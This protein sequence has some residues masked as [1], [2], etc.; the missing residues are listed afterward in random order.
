MLVYVVGVISGFVSGFF[1]TGG[2][3]VLLPA[4]IKILKVD[5]YKARGTTIS[6]MLVATLVAS[7]FYAKNDYIDAKMSIKVAIGGIIGGYIG[8]KLTNKLSREILMITFNVFVL[9]VAIQMIWG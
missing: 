6:S 1:G 8:A 3:L 4:L 9:Y 2:G 7:A 5:E